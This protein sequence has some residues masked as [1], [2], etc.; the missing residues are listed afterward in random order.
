MIAAG[1]I[2]R[3]PSPQVVNSPHADD[4]NAAS[5]TAE[6]TID[7]SGAVS[8]D[9]NF[10]DV[11][12]MAALERALD[13]AEFQTAPQLRSFLQFV[14][15]AKLSGQQEKLKGYKIAVEALGRST[16]FN[17]VLDPIVRVEAARLRRR[18][19]R[20]Y[21]G[22][23][24]SDPVRISIP[25]GSYAPEFCHVLRSS[26]DIGETEKCTSPEGQEGAHMPNLSPLSEQI[27]NKIHHIRGI[28]SRT[29]RLVRSHN[30]SITNERNGTSQIPDRWLNLAGWTDLHLKLAGKLSAILHY[31]I[32]V[33]TA[34][35]VSAICF[36]AGF[37]LASL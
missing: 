21:K 35:A 7:K 12:I 10:S 20:Y 30:F 6:R 29:D 1:R 34:F 18:L 31:R 9:R 19:A 15:H 22:T 2:S 33:L 23:G 26:S 4:K 17:P 36:L 11:Q 3:H 13:S 25:K 5:S 24:I 8:Q 32:P 16:D 27:R 37:V 28:E 14:V